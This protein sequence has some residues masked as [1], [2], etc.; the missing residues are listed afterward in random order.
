MGFKDWLKRGPKIEGKSPGGSEPKRGPKIEG[1]SPGGSDM[2]EYGGGEFDLPTIGVTD[3][4]LYPLHEEREKQY[5]ALFGETMTI[6]HELLP[7][8]PHIDVFIFKPNAPSRPFFTYITSGMSDLPMS[9]PPEVGAEMARAELIF[10]ADEADNSYAELLRRLAHFP[11]ENSTWLGP[12]HTMPNGTPPEPLFEGSELDAILF[13]PTVVR[14]DNAGTLTV[15][16]EPLNL[17]WVVPVT[18]REYNLKLDEGVGALYDIFDR[19]DH[20]VVFS[21]TR[22]SYV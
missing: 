6:Y 18:T 1:K 2:I 8:V 9:L 20:P 14:P 22:K 12:G 7:C 15:A 4:S 16:S 17:L 10:Y 11:H 21:P 13:T 3:E 5:G 19:V